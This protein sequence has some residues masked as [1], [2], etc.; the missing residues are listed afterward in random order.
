MLAKKKYPSTSQHIVMRFLINCN[1][2]NNTHN[3]DEFLENGQE[4]QWHHC[5]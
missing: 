3:C 1:N 2:I 4:L 5:S